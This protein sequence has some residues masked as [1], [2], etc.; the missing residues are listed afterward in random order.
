MMCRSDPM[1]PEEQTR[2]RDLAEHW[3]ASGGRI[4]TKFA[5]SNPIGS[6]E[7]RRLLELCADQLEA[8]MKGM[9]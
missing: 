3:R 6:R 8:E 1:T 5:E 9:I 4:E 7:A 2:L